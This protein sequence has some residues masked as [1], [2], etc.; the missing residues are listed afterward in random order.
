MILFFLNNRY[1]Y[2]YIEFYNFFR[3][4]WKNFNVLSRICRSRKE[5]L[6][7]LRI[8][9]AHPIRRNTGRAGLIKI[10]LEPGYTKSTTGRCHEM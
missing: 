7:F 8:G 6:N 3:A 1:I 5:T 9:L 2:G 4:A 10:F